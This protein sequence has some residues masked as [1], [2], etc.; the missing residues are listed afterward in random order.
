MGCMTAGN[1]SKSATAAL[2][3]HA[4][5]SAATAVVTWLKLR[6]ADFCAGTCGG[7][8]WCRNKSSRRYGEFFVTLPKSLSRFKR[9]GRQF[10]GQ[11]SAFILVSIVC[12]RS[13]TGLLS[14]SR[15]GSSSRSASRM[16]GKN[17]AGS[18]LTSRSR[19][20]MQSRRTWTSSWL[21]SQEA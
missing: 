13:L 3:K 4:A 12:I 11:F 2:R 15:K 5:I 6:S 10:L 19:F 1:A 18:D 17:L 21:T 16:T 14:L 9:C 8:T 20:L 7:V